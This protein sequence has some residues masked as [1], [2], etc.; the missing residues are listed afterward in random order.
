MAGRYALVVTDDAP[1]RSPDWRGALTVSRPVRRLRAGGWSDVEDSL[2]AEEPLEIR[3][4][5]RTA[6]GEVDRRNIAVTMR[7]PGHDFE[8]AAGFLHGEGVLRS[9]DDVADI[10]YCLDE[11]VSEEQ[12]FNIVTITLRPGLE[13]DST[14]LERNFYT[15]SSCGVCGKAALESLEVSGCAAVEDGIQVDATAVMR[16][17]AA[18]REAQPVFSKT[19]GLHAAGLFAPDGTL[20]TLREDVGRH[21]ALDK[22][23]GRS[24]LDGTLPANSGVLMLSGRAS[25]ELLQKALMA[26]VPVVAAVGAPSSLAVQLAESFNI[27]LAG[28][29]REDGMN[30]YSAAHRIGHNLRRRRG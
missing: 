1:A 27:T 2:A 28:F 22:V 14:R 30:I 15:T 18:L 4:Q 5:W 8:L 24:L 9:P 20:T 16:M 29:V 6:A 26:R 10:A 19:G 17:P 21:N 25:F 13:F 12:R 7:T 23:I 11:D 3:M